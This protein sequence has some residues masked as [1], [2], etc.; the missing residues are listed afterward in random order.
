MKVQVLVRL[1]PAVLDVQGKAVENGLKGLG[2]SEVEQVR[3]GKLIEFEIN[4]VSENQAAEQAKIMC[5]KL[6]ANPIIE[7]YE[8]RSIS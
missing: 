7:N 2:F 3:V 1:K 5:D 4:G 8:I 6:L